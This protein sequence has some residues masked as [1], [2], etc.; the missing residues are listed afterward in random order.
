ML[1]GGENVTLDTTRA[2]SEQG[3][4]LRRPVMRVHSALSVSAQNATLQLEPLKCTSLLARANCTYRLAA[5]GDSLAYTARDTADSGDFVA[6]FMLRTTV[7]ELDAFL[8]VDTINA[9]GDTVALN[10]SLSQGSVLLLDSGPLAGEVVS[11][12]R[13]ACLSVFGVQIGRAH[14]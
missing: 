8:H 13:A 7:L 4:E 3:A 6:R 1:A 9:T 12:V 14:V 5:S 2:C 11:H 10:F